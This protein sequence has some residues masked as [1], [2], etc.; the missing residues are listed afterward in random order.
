MSTPILAADGLVKE[1]PGVRALDGVTFTVAA[2][3]VH[4]LCGENGAGKS[5]LIK[6]LSGIHAHGSYG[7][8]VLV[9]GAE[10]RFAGIADAERAGI[11][12]IYQELALVDE[13]SVAENIMLGREPVRGGLI[14]WEALRREAAAVLERHGLDLDPAARCG[15][16]GTGRQQLV[17]IAK[18]L[19]KRSR[20]LILDEPTA[21]LTAAEADALL[22]I[23]RRLRAAGTAIVYISHRLDEVLGLADRIT[24]LRDGRSVAALDG[25]QATREALIAA[26]VGRPIADLYPRRAGTPGGEL[27]AV[28][29]LAVD[30]PGRR[31]SGIS[32]TVRAG[33]VLG[34]G[35]LMGAGRSEL[36]LHLFGAWGRRMA[37]RVALAGAPWAP[38]GPR[39]ALDGGLAL[40]V[41]DRKRQGLILDRGV[42]YNL[43]LASLGRL[44]GRIA[45]DRDAEAA[46]NRAAADSLR[47]KAADHEVAVATLSGGNQQKVV[48]G[49]ALLAEPR[50]VLLD[51]PTRG[52]DVG[53]RAEVYAI[54]NRLTDE[55]RAVV[56][57]SS[58]L[59]EL[60]GMSDRILMLAD[61]RGGRVFAR[62]E[63]DQAALL[64]AA[65]PERNAP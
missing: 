47:I 33:E 42:G 39:Q 21:A 65:I 23:L 25:P 11:A 17:E 43:S 34:I 10:A 13:L 35:G 46:R 7:G 40:V 55:G 64:A 36:L 48:I 12:V 60:L 3:E 18:A 14:D 49:K 15:D 24:V 8:R 20:V 2:G 37:G 28:E 62:G 54:I 56:L 51:E 30:G 31:L 61:G 50:V 52:I 22:G 4:A 26:M 57:V 58:D 59:P 29:G 53:A 9:D 63:A 38:A 5:T 6:T 45:I 19:A 41:E 16:L 27:L 1:F 32:F 44:P